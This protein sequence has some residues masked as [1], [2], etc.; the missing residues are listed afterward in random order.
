MDNKIYKPKNKIRIVTA[1]SLFDGHDVSINI[2]RRIIQSFGC[3][4][5]HLGHNRGAEEIVNCAIQEDAQAIAITS[6][7]GGHLEMLK[8]IF[9]LLKKYNSGHIKIFAGG[10]GVI[11]PGEIQELEEYGI[12]KVYSPDDG[13]ELGLLGMISDLVLRSDFSTEKYSQIY[14]KDIKKGNFKSLAQ[15]ITAIE[16]SKAGARELLQR[17]QEEIP[18]KTTPVIGITGTGGAGK[19]SIIDEFVNRFLNDF[20]DKKIGIISVDPTKRKTGGALLGD[21]IRMNSINDPRVFMRS[22]AT[23][24]SNVSLSSHIEDVLSVCKSS[25]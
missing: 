12:T 6:Y 24:Q 17:V 4:V 2:M 15:L 23:R 20:R 8:Y 1:A 25:F 19:S 14:P 3:E 21:R 9:D 5:I 16:N 22:L 10:G 11:L 7:Q 18:E 13:R